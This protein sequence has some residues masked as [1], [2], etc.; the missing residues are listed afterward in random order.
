MTVCDSNR[1][2]AVL[3]GGVNAPGDYRFTHKKLTPALHGAIIDEAHRRTG[4]STLEG[5]GTRVA[6][7]TDPFG[8]MVGLIENPHFELPTP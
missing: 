1:R 3:R 6:T 7:V 5:D 4:I 2:S 8:N